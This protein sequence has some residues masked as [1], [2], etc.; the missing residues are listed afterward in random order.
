MLGL[1]HGG[2]RGNNVFADNIVYSS[3]PEGIVWFQQG[4]MGSF[5]PGATLSVNNTSFMKASGGQIMAVQTDARVTYQQN[6]YYTAAPTNQWFSGRTFEQMIP[7]TG[8]AIT[9]ASYPDPN[10]NIVTYVRS[11]GANP[12]SVAQAIDWYSD[13]VPGNASLAGALANRRG[14]WDERFTSIAVINH[15][16]EGF[17]LSRLWIGVQRRKHRPSL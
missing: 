1:E 5:A 3:A 11:I 13:G 15:I 10:R 7:G 6:N 12:S 2:W 16:R 9:P 17:G 8:N 4:F 14:A